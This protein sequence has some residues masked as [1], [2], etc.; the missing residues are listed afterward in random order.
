M[1]RAGN[2]KLRVGTSEPATV[3]GK[4]P[5]QVDPC[6]PRPPVILGTINSL[7]Q[8]VGNQWLILEASQLSSSEA[9][10]SN[11]V[12]HIVVLFGLKRMA[13]G[14]GCGESILVWMA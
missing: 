10:N 6:S 14:R 12:T 2:M 13:S 8:R 11:L 1:W 3:E 7:W 9:E 4:L 5:V